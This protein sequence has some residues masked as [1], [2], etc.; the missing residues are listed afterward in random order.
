MDLNWQIV[1]II[2][3][4][5][6]VLPLYLSRRNKKDEKFPNKELTDK[7]K[8]LMVGGHGSQVDPAD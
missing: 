8:C 7:D 1:T 3:L 6:V 4:V 5:L 2:G